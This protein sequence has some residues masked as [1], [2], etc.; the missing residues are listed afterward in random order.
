M[1]IRLVTWKITGIKPLIQSNP[2]GMWKP[3]EVDDGELKKT[4]RKK[5]L[6]SSNSEDFQ[7]AKGQLYINE[8]GAH[9]HPAIAFWQGLL[10]ACDGRKLGTPSALSVI[11]Q[12]VA[13]I[14]EEFILYDPATLD[15]KNPQLLKGDEW[16]IDYRR[17]VNH[18]KDAANGGVCVVAIRPKFKRWGGLLTLEVDADFFTRKVGGEEV[19]DAEGLTGLLN[20]AGHY[21]GAGVGRMRVKAMVKQK[22]VWSGFGSGKYSAEL[23]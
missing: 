16:Q 10:M 5:S 19:F 17:A 1:D 22:P 14:E 3:P 11:T 21:Y 18:N 2:H 8:D 9:Y 6:R 23:K 13:L 12:A 20:V 4:G 7:A 15:G